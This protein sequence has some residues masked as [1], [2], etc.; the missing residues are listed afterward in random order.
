MRASMELDI[1]TMVS[2]GVPLNCQYGELVAT[3]V[4]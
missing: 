2:K 1:S 3:E 4:Y